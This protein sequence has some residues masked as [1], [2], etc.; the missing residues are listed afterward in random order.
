MEHDNGI[1]DGGSLWPEQMILA[2][3]D[4]SKQPFPQ[5]HFRLPVEQLTGTGDVGA[6]LARIVDRQRPMH[7]A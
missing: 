7:D 3:R 6:A 4:G 2:R 1:L 5:A